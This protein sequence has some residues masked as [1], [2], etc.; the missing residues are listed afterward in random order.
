MWRPQ[1]NAPS[2]KRTLRV[3]KNTAR[4]AK[5]QLLRSGVVDVAADLLFAVLGGSR[6]AQFDPN[7]TAALSHPVT[8][9][10]EH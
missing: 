2:S 5:T 9:Q 4:Q 10:Q 6:Q 7:K 3:G 8:Q 1:A